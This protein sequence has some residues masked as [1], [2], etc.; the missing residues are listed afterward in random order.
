MNN[1]WKGQWKPTKKLVKSLPV[2]VALVVS[3]VQPS[4][5]STHYFTSKL[6]KR[7]DVACNTIVSIMTSHLFAKFLPLLSNRLMPIPAT[8]LVNLLDTTSESRLHRLALDRPLAFW[9]FIPI[10]RK[11]KQVKRSRSPLPRL[12]VVRLLF[13]ATFKVG[14]RPKVNQFR[15]VRVYRQTVF[16]EGRYYVPAR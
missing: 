12:V 14:G 8:P 13:T 15:L 1:L 9:C 3:A 2:K 11:A 5:P 10:V 7:A 6:L 4:L 16:R